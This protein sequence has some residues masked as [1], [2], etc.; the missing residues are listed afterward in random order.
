LTRL[1]KGKFMIISKA[2][3][4]AHVQILA[5]RLWFMINYMVSSLFYPSLLV[6]R[7]HPAR[8]QFYL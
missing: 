8:I 7:D 1:S 3:W 6:E 5:L 2:C 4:G